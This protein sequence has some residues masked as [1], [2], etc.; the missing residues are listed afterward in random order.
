MK[1]QEIPESYKAAFIC[2]FG[3]IFAV[4]IGYILSKF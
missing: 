4:I 2:A 1:W 3:P